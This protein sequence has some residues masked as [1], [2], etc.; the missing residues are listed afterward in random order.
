M[1]LGSDR[2]TSGWLPVFFIIVFFTGVFCLLSLFRL[3]RTV[4]LPPSVETSGKILINREWGDSRAL[5]IASDHGR[6]VAYV[7]AETAPPEGS[8]IRVRG[9]LF[10]FR[11]ADEKKI[12]GFDEFLFWR[13]KGALRRMVVLDIKPLAPPTGIYKWRNYLETRIKYTLPDR[14]AG[15]MLALTVGARDK[16]LTDLHRSAGTLHLLSVSGFHVGILA[17]VLSL[18]FRR[19]L[20]KV[21]G[22]S[23]VMW[24]YIL[25]AG[26]PAGGVRAAVMVQIY[27]L[28]LIAGRPSSGFNSVSVA[29][30]LL[31]LCDPWCFF[32]IG[33]RLSM[34]AALFLSA[35]GPFLR[36]SWGHAAAASAMVWF[37]TA[38]QVAV[39]FR[40][41]PV[42]G[43]L[44]NMIAIPLFG[45]IFPMV[46]LFSLPSFFGLPF[47]S[48][49]SGPCE[50]MLGSWEIFSNMVVG[51]VPW[52]IRYTSALLA[53]SA[54]L[55]GAAAAFASGVRLP[56]IPFVAAI[57]PVFVLFFA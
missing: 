34:S 14:M 56:K 24:L 6:F 22:V 55:L 51:F 38:P 52:S 12:G 53:F 23:A 26:T 33:W 57:F 42:A 40:E 49:F 5:L 8:S 54:A 48:V 21:I 28:G 3:E 37:V 50:Y 4:T 19:G 43:L 29:G 35:F 27:L 46:F 32:D 16:K 47:A 20:R 1:L 30:V 10:D 13:A 15:Y 2:I 9:A 31:L 17:G 36:R 25:L 7:P 18:I 44:V 41:V 39:S 45:L 11:R